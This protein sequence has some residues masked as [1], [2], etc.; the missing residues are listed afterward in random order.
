MSDGKNVRERDMAFRLEALVDFPD[1]ALVNGRT[2][3]VDD[4]DALMVRLKELGISR[5]SWGY[6]GDGHGG[7]L[8]PTGYTGDYEGGWPHYDATYR[9]LGNPLKVAVEAGHRHGLEVY[10]YFKPYETGPGVIFPEGS[11]HAIAWGLLDCIG[12]KLGW[13]D[14][15]V[16]EHPELRIQRRSDDMPSWAATA[17]VA[18]IRLTKRDAAPTRITKDHLQIWTSPDNWRYQPAAVSFDL[19]ET[20]E[21]AP[22][23][24]RDQFGTLLTRE[25][26]PVRVLTLSGLQLTDKYIL[27]S[28]DFTDGSGD[29]TNSG[30]ALMTAVDAQG[31]EIPGVFASG[32][33]VWCA[34]LMDFR[35]GG[36]T[37]DYGWGGGQITL[38]AP[39]SNGKQGI[40]A[41]AR[42]RNAYLPGAL[43]ETEPAVRKFWLACLQEMIAAG[44]DGVDFREEGHSTHTDCPEDYGFNPVIL[45]QCGDVQGEELLQKI[46]EVRGNAYTEFLAEC[47]R[48]LANVGK[49]M[50][51]NLQVDFF[52]PDPVPSRLLAYPAN[53]DFQWRRWL[54]EGL[55]D[56]A[57]LR[58]YSLPSYD[59][60]LETVFADSVVKEMLDR[61]RQHDIPITVNR[62][63][64]APGDN[65]TAELQYVRSDERFSGFIFYEVYDY[66]RFAPTPGDCSITYAPVANAAATIRR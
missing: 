40:I 34:N 8:N 51:Y 44:V 62:Y 5:V 9:E 20:V 52:R 35:Q 66:L 53:L 46:A 14:P 22:R 64:M 4:I 26:D 50:R 28:T 19:Q 29:F 38:D 18:S 45:A 42:G 56:E 43:C 32:S 31:R 24:V 36:L 11:P 60:P 61:C 54:D 21:T 59:T 49:R 39:N 16:R 65:L 63:V 30:L 17:T 10:A 12:G 2:L 3:T 41:F 25:G 6:Y 13:M 15:F 1:D 48:R 33:T 47:K 37:F 58:T 57:I 55:M 7:L 23:D 27:V